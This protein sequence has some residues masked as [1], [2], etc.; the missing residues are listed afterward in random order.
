VTDA[1][2]T[3]APTTGLAMQRAAEIRPAFLTDRPLGGALQWLGGGPD[4]V[5]AP[6]VRIPEPVSQALRRAAKRVTAEKEFGPAA[7]VP[8][9]DAQ[10]VLGP[11]SDAI[12]QTFTRGRCAPVSSGPLTLPILNRFRH[13]FVDEIDGLRDS[14]KPGELGRALHAFD[15]VREAMDRDETE[16]FVTALESGDALDLVVEIAHD[17]RSPLTA[18]LMLIEMLRRSQA[19]G[20]VDAQDRQLNLVYSATFGLSALVNDVIALARGGDRLIDRELVPFSTS[21]VINSVADMLRPIAVERGLALH[22]T[23]PPVDAR[24]GQPIA[25]SRILLNLAS[26]ALKYTPAGEVSISAVDLC[27]THVRFEVADTGPGIPADVMPVLFEPFTK[28]TQAARGRRFSRTG[29][30]LSICRKLLRD[31]GSE[32]RL[33]TGPDKGTRFFFELTL[34]AADARDVPHARSRGGIF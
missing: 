30:G 28:R 26:N 1:I 10:D 2:G 18:V 34:P 11:L 14:L 20:A 16:R 29:L 9:T 5:R 31:M 8:A 22:V 7:D 24:V 33:E 27:P 21:A 17:M 32:L 6:V 13:A 23:P 15:Q 12:R 4:D 19:E 3:D 25:L